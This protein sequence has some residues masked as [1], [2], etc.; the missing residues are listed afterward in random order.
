LLSELKGIKLE[1]G[2]VVAYVNYIKSIR[3]QKN[4]SLN[5]ATKL[6]PDFFW[7]VFD[8]KAN[9]LIL[10]T[11]MTRK[12]Y[13][14]AIR[15]N[16]RGCIDITLREGEQFA[17]SYDPTTQSFTPHEFSL[18]ESIQILKYAKD[19]GIQLAE[20][21]NPIA[22][23]KLQIIRQLVQLTDRPL[24][25]T[26]IRNHPRDVAAALDSGVEGLSILATTDTDRLHSMQR[27]PEQNLAILTDNIKLAKSQSKITRV[28]IEHSWNR[29]LSEIIPFYHTAVELGV[30]RIGLANTRGDAFEFEVAQL[31]RRV[32]ASL[33]QIDIE[34]HFHNDLGNATPNSL[35]ALAEGGNW[36]TAT[37]GGFS[38]RIGI[39]PW[40]QFFTA[41]LQLDPTLSQGYH[42]TYL[43]QAENYLA[44]IIGIPIPPTL[45]TA[46]NAFS[47]RAGVHL[48]ELRSGRTYLY[49]PIDPQLLGNQRQLITGTSISGK[50]TT[51]EKQKLLNQ[52]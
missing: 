52:T 39:T 24:L 48:N 14:K 17:G 6:S 32:R 16:W 2:E 10:S 20:V 42:T 49:E 26:H 45:N 47:Y 12:T 18:D 36:T 9:I 27:T 7:G 22:P 5:L 25:T 15:S 38:E 33:P 23:G 40:S 37:F 13:A 1:T 8:A 44:Q 19:I 30:D 21:P 4:C 31:L 51:A 35:R 28:S 11:L 46:P 34:L 29:P 43:T 50:M 41:I 3:L